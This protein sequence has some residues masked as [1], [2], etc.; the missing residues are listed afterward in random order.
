MIWRKEGEKLFTCGDKIGIVACS[1]GLLQS[2]KNRVTELMKTLTELKLVPAL[3]P[4]IFEVNSVFSGTVRERANAFLSFYSD[5]NIK[6][7]FDISGGDIANEL[8]DFLDYDL[9]KNNPKP[10]WGY[11][12]LTTILNAIYRKTGVPSYLYQIKNLIW[13]NK[14]NQ[15]R[16]F[17]NTVFNNQNSLYDIQWKFVQG[18]EMKGI[19]IG[20]NIRCF[21]KL[22]GTPYMPEFKNK[23]LFLESYGGNAALMTTYLCQL[24]QLGAYKN[25]AGLLL[26]TFTKMEE[27]NESPGI[28]DLVS[29]IID[30]P[31]LPIAKTDEV[32]HNNTSKCLIIGKEYAVN[33]M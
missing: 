13:E 26:G 2:D 16:D 29:R 14:R 23:I 7:I 24:K 31:R 12:D 17:K 32:G 18:S 4:Y 6:A 22:A 8:L 20:G 33:D 25:I 9:I 15:I 21:L 10:F 5:K 3:S 19:V 1:N 28:I 11:S 30:N 27:M